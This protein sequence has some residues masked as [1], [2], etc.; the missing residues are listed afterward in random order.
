MVRFQ[1]FGATVA[2]L[3]VVGIALAPASCKAPVAERPSPTTPPPLST[4]TARE[5]DAG[6]V[7][8]AA[9]A[10]PALQPAG[11]ATAW[12]DALR[13]GDDAALFAQTEFPFELRDEGTRGTPGRCSA[14]QRAENAGRSRAALDCLL[15][16]D[17]VL[18]VMRA[19]SVEVQ[20]LEP[21]HLQSWPSSWRSDIAPAL[22][23]FGAFFRS[24]AAAYEFVILASASGVRS[25]WKRGFDAT[26]EVRLA[27]E[28]L[29]ALSR[30]DLGSL[31]RL[32]TYPL[33]VRDTEV[34]AHCGSRRAATPQELPAAVACLMND[35][36]F[37][38]A[39][40][41]GVRIRAA[42]KQDF[43]PGVFEGWR[44]PEH[45]ALWPATALIANRAGNEYDLALLVAKNGV[46]V[47]WKR[48]SFISA[49]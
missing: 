31:E 1:E 8:P 46:R 24:D 49:D 16:D 27:A 41:N 5:G 40:G 12:L 15:Q 47:F 18:R 38:D 29:A 2:S 44:R 48:G 19:T 33:E 3:M 17:L 10:V 45:A 36:I 37:D 22:I 21:A 32:T 9:E 13:L 39:L 4:A 26:E 42:M 11:H 20:R 25:V 23:P 14:L 6:A 43:E 7:A 30:K 28:W 34:E 35:P